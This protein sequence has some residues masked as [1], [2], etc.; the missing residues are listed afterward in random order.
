MQ[1]FKYKLKYGLKNDYKKK[2]DLPKFQNKRLNYELFLQNYHRHNTE[3]SILNID[4]K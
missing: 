2:M 4:K 1:I 3:P